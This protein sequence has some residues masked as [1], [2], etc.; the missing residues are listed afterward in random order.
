VDFKSELF[1]VTTVI[2]WTYLLHAHYRKT[3]VEY[4]QIDPK[5]KGKRRKFLHT[6]HGATRHWSLEQCLECKSC[7][8][9]KAVV[10]NLMFLIGIRHEI[11]HQ[12]TRKI[13]DQ[14]SAKFMAAALNFN[15]AIKRL[16][17]KKYGLEQ[18]QA[19][20][21]QFSTIDE[22]TAKT[23]ME[24]IDLPQHIKSFVV[25]FESG[26][27]Q[28]EFDD[29]RF[30]YRIALV[31][32]VSNNKNTAD[33]MVQI[34]PSGSETANALNEVIL[35]ETERRKYRP[36]SIVKQMKAEGYTKFDMKQHTDLWQEKD[37]KNP[38]HQYGVEVEGS[39][40]WYESW[41]SEVRKHCATHE[42]RYKPPVSVLA[43]PDVAKMA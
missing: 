24:D 28:E 41:V 16:F 27:S 42:A 37:A 4:R 29:P 7:P 26:M 15:A 18:E 25:Q 22:K 23:L 30:S 1:I 40:L 34:V 39:W 38:K 13:D 8:V 31:K 43:E 20:S 11:E 17:D 5:W 2:A 36:S 10:S 32:K 19:F 3:G 14:L 21:I 33:R 6:T 9:D 12:M 35:K